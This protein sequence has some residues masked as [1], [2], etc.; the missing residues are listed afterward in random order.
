MVA[1]ADSKDCFL[2]NWVR[3]SCNCLAISS[4]EDEE[5]GVAIVDR[6]R[7]EDY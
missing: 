7:F 6:I 3:N 4:S 2:P 5:D 1:T